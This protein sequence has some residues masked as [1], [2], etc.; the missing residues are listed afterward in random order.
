MLS[1][2]S[3]SRGVI[4]VKKA[5]KKSVRTKQAK[6][7][8]AGKAKVTTK[9]RH[10]KVS[11]KHTKVS[12]RTTKVLSLPRAVIKKQAP[13]KKE[14]VNKEIKRI[15]DEKEQLEM[16]Q[17]LLTLSD[18]YARQLLI[19]LGGENALEIVRNFEGHASDEDLAKKLKL[20]ISDVRATLNKLHS[21]GLVNYMRDKDSETGW[22]SYSWTLNRVRIENWVKMRVKESTDLIEGNKGDHY[23]CVACGSGSIVSFDVATESEFRCVSCSKSLEFLDSDR[24]AELLYARRAGK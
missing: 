23:F 22:Y 3:F 1:L 21:E 17:L 15:Y 10:K 19:D 16:K 6:P 8:S 5:A 13:R 7:N 20:K 14:D 24:I 9:A 12:S 2:L 4:M 11:A 18:S